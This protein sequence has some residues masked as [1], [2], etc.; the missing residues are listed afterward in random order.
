MF[1]GT[2]VGGQQRPS[3]GHL[4]AIGNTLRLRKFYR[5]SWTTACEP[6]LI[7]PGNVDGLR[8][9]AE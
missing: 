3:Y 8:P 4:N 5:K 1:T 9:D 2:A 7:Q 6:E